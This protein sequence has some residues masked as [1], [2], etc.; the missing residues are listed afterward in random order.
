MFSADV[1]GGGEGGL[2]ISTPVLV[3]EASP[4]QENIIEYIYIY[5]YIYIYTFLLY[6]SDAVDELTCVVFVSCCLCF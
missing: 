1:G 4:L 5:I 3:L 2:V 6:T